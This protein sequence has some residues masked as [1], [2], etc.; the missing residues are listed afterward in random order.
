M[1]IVKDK[2]IFWITPSISFFIFNFDISGIS[3][4]DTAI[5]KARGKDIKT[6]TLELK[7][8]YL[9]IAVSSP[10]I[11]FNIL[12]IVIESIFFPI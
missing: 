4:V 6:S 10:K 8:P 3:A 5:L 2:F 1:L 9:L 12:T 7:I 11:F